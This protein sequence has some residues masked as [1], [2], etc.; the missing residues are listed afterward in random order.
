MAWEQAGVLESQSKLVFS[1]PQ[2]LRTFA[3]AR[4]YVALAFPIF[5]AVALHLENSHRDILWVPYALTLCFV[6]VP[7]V[8]FATLKG[9]LCKRGNWLRTPKTGRITLRQRLESFW[10]P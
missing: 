4:A 7:F 2:N 5:I 10:R 6:A 3:C 9:L 8:A 1:N